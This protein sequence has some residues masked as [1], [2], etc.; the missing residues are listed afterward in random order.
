MKNLI[1]KEIKRK[2]DIFSA[3]LIKLN[4]PV[5]CAIISYT[6]VSLSIMFTKRLF[7]LPDMTSRSSP[8]QQ[9]ST[10]VSCA[11]TA[12]EKCCSAHVDMWL[13]ATLVHREWKNVYFVVKTFFPEW[14]WDIADT[15][16][17]LYCYTL[18]SVT[19]TVDILFLT[20]TDILENVQFVN[21][22]FQLIIIL[23]I[24]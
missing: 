18:L 20:M 15:I 17:L 3:K 16:T 5:F 19:Y 6:S 21:I 12:N 24:I 22:L 11:L 14:R 8:H 23:L 9:R 2:L 1:A 7:F 10:S 13:V 4:I